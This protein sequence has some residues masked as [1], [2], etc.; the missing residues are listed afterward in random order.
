[1]PAALRIRHTLRAYDIIFATASVPVN[2]AVFM[3]FFKKQNLAFFFKTDYDGG[4]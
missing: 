2:C 3:G 1:M 4:G